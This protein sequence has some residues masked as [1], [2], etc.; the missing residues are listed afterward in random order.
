MSGMFYNCSGLTSLDSI[1]NWDTSN[2]T[3]MGSMFSYCTGLTSLDLSNWDTSKVTNMFQMFCNCLGLTEIKMGGDV[4]KVTNVSGM[5]YDINTT[6]TFYYNS[7][8]DYSKI[9]EQLPSKWT[10]VPCTMVDGV[11]IP[12]E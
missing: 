3:S 1:S 10:V 2:V 5:F 11:L 4:S 8:Y 12:N 7:A 6:G 9:I